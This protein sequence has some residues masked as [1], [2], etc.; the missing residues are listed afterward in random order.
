MV[1]LKGVLTLEAQQTIVQLVRD[2]GV[3]ESGFYSPTTREGSMHLQMMCLGKHWNPVTNRYEDRRSNLDNAPAP[4]LP[5][6]LWELVSEAAAA[7]SA[8]CPSIP[9]P[10]PGIALVNFYSHA[11][12]LGLHQDKSES[13]AS[14]DRGSPIVS[15]S[16]GDS[17]E[18]A[19]SMTRPDMD[20]PLGLATASRRPQSVRL[21]SGDIFVFGGPAR[22]LFHGVARI[23]ASN[24]PK[25]LIMAPGRLNLTFREP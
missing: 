5:A 1:L 4:P 16:I 6:E 18:F 25:E 17:C 11:G 14:L 24:R 3:G 19:Y 21:D 15:A 13:R 2:L 12:R 10:Q 9:M 8:A 23:F 7:A 20:D 22:M